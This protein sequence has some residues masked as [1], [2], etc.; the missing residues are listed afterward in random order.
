MQVLTEKVVEH[1]LR[2]KVLSEH[3]LDR[4]IGSSPA[5][6]YGLVNR[7]LKAHELIRIRR[8]LYVLP[9]K[10][11]TV[12]PHPF[13][14]AQALEPG[15]YISFETALG[16]HGWIPEQV[17]VIASVVPGRKSSRLEHPVLGSF[18]FH[19]LA[20]QPAGFLEL[21]ERRPLGSQV[22]LLAHPLRAIV[23]LITL[24]RLDWQGMPWLTQGLRIEETQLRT[25]TQRQ[26][27]TLLTVYKQK[28]PRK[29]LQ[30]FAQE[31]HLD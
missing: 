8:G 23:D 12:P 1:G 11:R 13:A 25:I 4:L 5:S 21:I 6:R 10:Y 20:L 9:S 17:R 22:A 15:S 7:A 3:Q 18:T 28:R 19:P 2:D 31:M 26:V 24:R 30:A 29:F 27:Q 16:A 14:V